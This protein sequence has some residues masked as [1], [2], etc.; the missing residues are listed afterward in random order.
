MM[1]PPPNFAV[2]VA[3]VF[4]AVD[5]DDDNT[6]RRPERVSFT[7]ASVGAGAEFV[8]LHMTDQPSKAKTL[9]ARR[10]RTSRARIT[11]PRGASRRGG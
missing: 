9:L 10:W 7:P 3:A 1:A 2:G 5:F 11:P 4:A 8:I 6:K